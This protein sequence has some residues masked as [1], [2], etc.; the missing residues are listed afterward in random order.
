MHGGDVEVVDERLLEPVGPV[1]QLPERASDLLVH[2]VV[3]C[4]LGEGHLGDGLDLVLERVV[5]PVKQPL[6]RRGV[7]PP[8]DLSSREESQSPTQFAGGRYY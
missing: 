7:E 5:Q 6:V 3:V 8:L 4:H 2:R 1:A